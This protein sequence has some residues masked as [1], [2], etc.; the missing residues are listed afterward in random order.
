MGSRGVL[1]APFCAGLLYDHI[2]KGTPILQEIN[3]NR[4]KY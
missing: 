4:F 2:E 3:I 1:Q